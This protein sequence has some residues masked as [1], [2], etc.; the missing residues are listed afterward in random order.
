VPPLAITIRYSQRPGA[1][2][3]IAA[4]LLLAYNGNILVYS[5]Y[6]PYLFV[7]LAGEAGGRMISL[8]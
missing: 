1:R 3:R 6:F 8:C 7:G 4:G 5:Q 2:E